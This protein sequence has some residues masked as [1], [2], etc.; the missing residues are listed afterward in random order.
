MGEKTTIAWTD[1]TFNPWWGCRK[2]SPACDHCYAE[3]W[4]KRCGYGWGDAPRRFFGD[5]HW[6]E[7]LIWNKTPSRVFC[8]SMADVF[9][10]EVDQSHRDRLWAL[11]RATPNLTWQLLT[12]RIG[13]AKAMLP[14]CF[15]ATTYPNVWLGATVVTQAEFD[16][17]IGK[18][19]DVPARVRWLSV[20]P[21]LE[22][23]W[24]LPWLNTIGAISWVV[25]GGESGAKARPYDVRW[26]RSVVKQ[27]REAAIF[28]FVKQLGSAAGFKHHAG[29]DPSEWPSDLRIREF[30]Q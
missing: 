11:I 2:V 6:N 15:S 27:C 30:P 25:T 7:P 24:M 8:A 4:A 26:A 19:V 18:L 29:A 17:D 1:H 3:T 20:E 22:E 21:Q 16:R 12:K 9:D 28:P 23:I 13:N 10:N 5:K 14:S